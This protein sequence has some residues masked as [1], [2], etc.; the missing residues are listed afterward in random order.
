M[1]IYLW[2]EVKE[3][4]LINEEHIPTKAMPAM[5]LRGWV[6]SIEAIAVAFKCNDQRLLEVIRGN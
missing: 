3:H 6:R 1:Q 5:I 4:E 2:V